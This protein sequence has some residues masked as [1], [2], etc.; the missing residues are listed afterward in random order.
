[1]WCSRVEHL[2]DLERAILEWRPGSPK[3]PCCVE[4]RGE[5]S[6]RGGESAQAQSH[7]GVASEGRSEK[8]GISSEEEQMEAEPG[9]K[10]REAEDKKGNGW[11]RKQ[12][13]GAGGPSLPSS[14]QHSTGARTLH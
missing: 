3:R 2:G 14:W 7:S 10:F 13:E 4:S 9:W 11:I 6:Q 8:P 12:R 1:M 5:N